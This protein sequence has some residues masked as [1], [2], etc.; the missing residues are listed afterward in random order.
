MND[1]EIKMTDVERKIM[2]SYIL[3]TE[4]L[5]EYLGSGYEI[6]I[7]SL[8]DLEHS[9]IK[10]YNGHHSGRV[11]GAPITDLALSFL[12]ETEREE[13][14]GKCTPYFTHDKHGN[15]IRSTTIGIRGENNRIIGMLCINFYMSTP[16]SSL[17]ESLGMGYDGGGGRLLPESFSTNIHDMLTQTISSVYADV[18]GDAAI[19]AS[20]KTR[21][22]VSELYNRGIFSIK[23]AV[24]K[25]AELIGVS[26]NTVYIYLREF[27]EGGK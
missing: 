19:P 15:R 4:G 21:E 20:Q 18:I 12:A 7:H 3:M 26:R 22:I 5:A 2:D 13:D 1:L 8:E 16:V 25:T 24:Q 23:D 6:V 17:L 9:A 11:E 10:I 14:D 27:E